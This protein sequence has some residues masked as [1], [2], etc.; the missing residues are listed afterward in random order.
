MDYETSSSHTIEVQATSTNNRYGSASTAEFIIDVA[1]VDEAPQ[2]IGTSELEASLSMSTQKTI[3]FLNFGITFADLMMMIQPTITTLVHYETALLQRVYLLLRRM[4]MLWTTPQPSSGELSG[5][6]PLMPISM[7]GVT[8][9]TSA[10]YCWRQQHFDL[11]VSDGQYSEHKD[12]CFIDLGGGITE[13][14]RM[15]M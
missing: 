11:T 9:C 13:A 15:F 2:F 6:L 7:Y 5:N 8:D 4:S 12:L 10:G 3:Q 14:F 1:D